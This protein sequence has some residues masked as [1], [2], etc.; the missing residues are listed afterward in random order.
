M[1]AAPSFDVTT[2]TD[3]TLVVTKGCKAL[4]LRKGMRVRVANAAYSPDRGY[5]LDLHYNGGRRTLCAASSARLKGEELSLNDGN[6]LHNVRL[7]RL[8]DPR[9]VASFEV[10]I[11][12]VTYPLGTPA[13]A[14][15]A[16]DALRR[17]RLLDAPILA[18]LVDGTTR[19][20]NQTL[21]ILD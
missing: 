7:K 12:G 20:A 18:R 3:A 15:I 9:A 13:A 4:P 2:L 17:A 8:A 5:R 16:R 1:T 10:R 19:Q 14:A 21:S 11:Q 6:P